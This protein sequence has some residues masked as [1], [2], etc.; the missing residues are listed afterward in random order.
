MAW[1]QMMSNPLNHPELF[2][3]SS[4]PQ[5]VPSLVPQQPLSLFQLVDQFQARRAQLANMERMQQLAD[6]ASQREGR[7]E[8]FGRKRLEAADAKQ[9]ASDRFQRAK[10]GE[11][12]LAAARKAIGSGRHPGA[13]IVQDENG[14]PV[15]VQWELSGGQNAAPGNFR[16]PAIN[17]VKSVSE[18]TV[19]ALNMAADKEFQQPQLRVPSLAGRAIPP[20]PSLQEPMAQPMEQP[21]QNT[22]FVDEN[23]DG[24]VRALSG[25]GDET[26]SQLP[27]EAFPPMAKEGDRFAAADVNL[28]GGKG[29]PFAEPVPPIPLRRPG[30]PEGIP[31]SSES[32]SMMSPKVRGAVWRTKGMPG[33]EVTV[34]P[35]EARMAGRE[36]A[37]GAVQNIDQALASEDV[38]ENQKRQ[39][40][41]I[42]PLV[43]SGLPPKMALELVRANESQVGREMGGE[44]RLDQIHT[45]GEESR[46]TEELRQKGRL[47]AISARKKGRGGGIVT[48]SSGQGSAYSRLKPFERSR[49]ENAITRTIKAMDAQMNWTKLEGIGWDRLA[50]ALQNIRAKGALGGTQ[51]MEAMMNFFG[52]IRGGVP[53][54]NE[55]D[56]WKN[57]TSTLWTKLEQLGLKASNF[58]GGKNGTAQDREAFS[59]AV[60]HLPEAQRAS[61]EQAIVESMKAVK[62]FALKNVQAQVE[63]FKSGDTA[64]HE[65]AQ[66]L[67]NSKLRFI[68]EKPRQWYPDSRL[69]PDFVP[70]ESS[71]TSPT[72]AKGGKIT[73][74]DLLEGGP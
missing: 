47:E 14:N 22:F 52:Y 38:P 68:G 21:P 30:E 11:A 31:P 71:P 13:M 45:Q 46:T 9:S 18:P 24:D 73:I 57:V 8:E 67:L 56:E 32:T 2:R 61:L 63:G 15:T 66:D 39:L 23:Q 53:A 41:A 10:G 35:E 37:Q 7:M 59:Q 33:G 62:G 48:Q 74:K 17:S 70:G 4:V 55:T 54:K 49:I 5:S 20:I 43:M 60:A 65:R 34:D 28:R 6:L 64:M 12:A 44:Q 69:I 58:G 16:Q 27:I 40:L 51:Q 29:N 50:L 19:P 1:N 3:M 72:G 42:R 25:P 26:T 36:E